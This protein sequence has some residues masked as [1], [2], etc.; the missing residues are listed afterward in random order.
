MA[1]TQ[2]AIRELATSVAPSD[3]ERRANVLRVG[4]D[5]GS[6]TTCFQLSSGLGELLVPKTFRLPTLIAYGPEGPSGKKVYVG[7][8]ALARRHE[9]EIVNPLRTDRPEVIADFASALRAL[10]DPDG[11][12]ELWGVVNCPQTGTPDDVR[13]TRSVAHQ[14]FDR[15]SLLDPALLMATGFGS[16][17][18][19][20][21]S[22][23]ID[24]GARAVRV[25]VVNGGAPQTRE[26][27]VIPGGGDAVSAR[28]RDALNRRYPG[29]VVTGVTA[30]A[31]KEKFAHVEPAE[32][33]ARIEVSFRQETMPLDIAATIRHVCEPLA[34][35]ILKALRRVIE[36][37]T[38]DRV[39][40]LASN[41]VLAGGCAHM[42][43]LAERM[44]LELRREFIRSASV[45]TID[46][47]KVL[48]TNG[49]LR[50][51]HLLGE[52]EW[53]FPVFL[54]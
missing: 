20:R 30:D 44:R 39:E 4:L 10:M 34:A 25:A 41:I 40:G 52:E 21:G 31:I 43:G 28:L 13:L 29:L 33:P 22:I 53:E 8:D 9:L 5:L 3:G 49:A 1:V 27:A 16:Q 6:H 19:A 24:A 26:T 12:R 7:E 47:P 11:K 48:V 42:P 35:D 2:G 15:M 38:S 18:V 37:C 32:R 17:E 51:A 46:D 23:W 45:R 54:F 14:V 36:E 50:W